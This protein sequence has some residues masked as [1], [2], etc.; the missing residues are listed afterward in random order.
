[1]ISWLFKHLV[2]KSISSKFRMFRLLRMFKALRT[3]LYFENHSIIALWWSTSKRMIDRDFVLILWRW[4]CFHQSRN[5]LFDD[6]SRW[7]ARFKSTIALNTSSLIDKIS[8]LSN[9]RIKSSKAF[10][11]WFWNILLCFS[12]DLIESRLMKAVN[13]FTFTLNILAATILL[14]VR[15]S[16]KNLFACFIPR[17][18][19]M[20]MRFILIW[21]RDLFCFEKSRLAVE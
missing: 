17:M 8:C 20:N 14:S 4:S 18:M 13:V 2:R 21:K 15:F 12:F 1:M 9:D 5:H 19:M 11:S 10:F 3:V 7:W 6:V 16:F